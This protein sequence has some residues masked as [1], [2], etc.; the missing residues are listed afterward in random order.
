MQA[1]HIEDT[2]TWTTISQQKYTI[3]INNGPEMDG[4][5]AAEMGNYNAIMKS[6]PRYQACKFTN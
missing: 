4:K 6:C 2:T 5:D 1:S 3:Q